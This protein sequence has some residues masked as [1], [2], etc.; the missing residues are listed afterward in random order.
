MTFTDPLRDETVNDWLDGGIDSPIVRDDEA[1]Y[2]PDFDPHL[3]EG[4]GEWLEFCECPFPDLGESPKPPPSWR[5]L[6]TRPS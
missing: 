5:Q 2:D 4:C 3:C 6:V 1:E